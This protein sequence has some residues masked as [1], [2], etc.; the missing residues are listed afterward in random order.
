MTD[1]ARAGRQRLVAVLAVLALGGVVV[2]AS[3]DE[4]VGLTSVLDDAVVADGLVIDVLV[5]D[6]LVV[7]VVVLGVVVVGVVV[8]GTPTTC[9]APPVEITVTDPSASSW[10]VALIAEARSSRCQASSPPLVRSS[11]SPE[12][13]EVWA[14]T[15]VCPV[16]ALTSLL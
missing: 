10:T 9:A 5:L 16:T 3:V 2:L 12:S 11:G 6:V 1:R 15:E 13:S 4:L 14:S 8:G 7:G